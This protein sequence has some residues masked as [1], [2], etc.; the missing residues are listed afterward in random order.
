M[1]RLSLVGALLGIASSA[2]AD[3]LPLTGEALR[4]E[5]VGSLL[6]IDTPLAGVVIP[7]RVS[8]NG[9]VSGEAGPLASTLGAAHDRGRWWINN[10]RLCV[11]WFRWFEAQTRCITV[12]HEGA[13]IYWKEEGGE[14]GTATIIKSSPE[15]AKVDPPLI[16]AV[17]PSTPSTSPPPS[18]EASV[19]IGSVPAPPTDST[20]PMRFA[21]VDLFAGLLPAS[22]V[23]PE[24]YKLG[25]GTSEPPKTVTPLPV[26]EKD[27]PSPSPQIA[28]KGSKPIVTPMPSFRVT[29]V[30]VDDALIIRSG[31]SE[32]HPS[33]GVIPPDGKGVLIVG[34]CRDVWCPVRHQRS[35]GWVNRYYLADENPSPRADGAMTASDR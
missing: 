20:E 7:V 21:A 24:P 2:S 16:E 1:L 32:Y 19:A 13:K 22:T 5:L 28:M 26:A 27:Q 25:V 11:K 30:A 12:E 8:A 33:V 3:P 18:S 17:Q 34:D 31:P 35:K 23:E 9:L 10:D 6:E 29:R 14:S 15:L 4:Q